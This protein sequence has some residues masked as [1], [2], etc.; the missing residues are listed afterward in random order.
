[1]KKLTANILFITLIVA[2]ILFMI[3]M[4]FWLKTESKD[5][6]LNPVKYFHDKNEHITCSCYG[7]G[8]FEAIKGLGRDK[9]FIIDYNIQP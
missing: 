9:E 4:V 6:T 3:W 8:S 2:V 1:M 5:C 7:E